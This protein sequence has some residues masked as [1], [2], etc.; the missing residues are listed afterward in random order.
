MLKKI[1]IIIG[2]LAALMFLFSLAPFIL[3]PGMGGMLMEGL[4]DKI[5]G[6]NTVG[7]V[8][9]NRR[10][11]RVSIQEVAAPG[12]AD[13]LSPVIGQAYKI[14][15]LKED[16]SPVRVEFAYNEADI[17]AGIDEANLR[18]F[19]WVDSGEK[20]FWR[21]IDSYADTSQNKVVAELDSF[22]ILAVRAP[23]AYY[24]SAA[25][26][27]DINQDLQSLTKNVPNYTCGIFIIV[28]EELIEWS[29]GEMMEAYIRPFG[30]REE[31]KD[32][33][34]NPASVTPPVSF[35]ELIDRET[36]GRVIQY[37][38]SAMVDW[39]KDHEESAEFKGSV[40]DQKGNPLPGVK[41]IA[42]KIKYSSEFGDTAAD[43]TGS[44]KIDL[45]S[46]IYRVTVNPTGAGNQKYKNCSQEE[47]EIKLH[48]FGD[49]ADVHERGAKVEK[50]GPFEQDFTLQ[51]SEYYIDN[52]SDVPFD[53]YVVYAQVKGAETHTLSGQQTEAKR[54]GYGWE[55]TWV[56][57]D[58][59]NAVMDIGD[60]HLTVPGLPGT[61]DIKTPGNKSEW[62]D[63]YR[64]TFTLPKNPKV[65]DTFKMHFVR[66]A[67]AY[68]DKATIQ[69]GT[70]EF[71][72]SPNY[73]LLMG[74]GELSGGE[75]A[76]AVEGDTMGKIIEIN[77]EDGAVIDINTSYYEA[78]G[79]APRAIIKKIGS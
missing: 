78:V 7:E 35:T 10:E 59:V 44:F 8:T 50:Q 52:V 26:V 72:G 51:C 16:N 75:T 38:I 4:V 11:S 65:G 68:K 55:G 5:K 40:R 24:M 60:Y 66:P 20:K 25:E 61:M 9:V 22:S 21:P 13:P 28:D 23:I 6:S 79:T 2:V 27:A 33:A 39:Q 63:Y 12:K 34:A 58:N 3:S 77:G 14:D 62:Q 18:L 46:G 48:A 76:G 54:G 15:R 47:V 74:H 30:E 37:A 41:L 36:N 71:S 31:Y 73:Y 57:D 42:Q 19:K 1:L 32:C 70:T 64:Y 69:A 49:L 67:G 53:Q 17:P 43:E 45:P 29:N 56:V